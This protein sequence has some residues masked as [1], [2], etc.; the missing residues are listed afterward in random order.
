MSLSIRFPSCL[1]SRKL[2]PGP[3]E[4]VIVLGDDPLF[5][6]DD[7]VVGDLDLLGTHLGAALGDVAEA[8]ASARFDQLEPIV[9]VEW[10]HL[11]RRQAD[12]EARTGEARLI[13]LVV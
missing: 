12:E 6:G 5:E 3:Y 10:V 9:T 2:T 7:R 4:R 13:R 11:Q 8:Q 1:S